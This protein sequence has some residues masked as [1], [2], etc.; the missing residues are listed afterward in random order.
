[1]EG[2]TTTAKCKDNVCYF[3]YVSP[4]YNYYLKDTDICIKSHLRTIQDYSCAELKKAL[5]LNEQIC[6]PCPNQWLGCEGDRTR[7]AKCYSLPQIYDIAIS[8]GCDI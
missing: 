3:Y 7:K 8:R 5:L 4:T 6:I 1:M 2:I